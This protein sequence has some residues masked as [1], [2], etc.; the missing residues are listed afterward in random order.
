M[1]QE[2]NMNQ[3]FEIIKEDTMNKKSYSKSKSY[4]K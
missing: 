2:I 1:N 4:S 3:M